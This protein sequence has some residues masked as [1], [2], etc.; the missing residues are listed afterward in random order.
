MARIVNRMDPDNDDLFG[1]TAEAEAKL[2]EMLKRWEAEGFS[3]SVVEEEDGPAYSISDKN[4]RPVGIYYV[5]E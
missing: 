1:S 4:G 2:T 5:E 3:V